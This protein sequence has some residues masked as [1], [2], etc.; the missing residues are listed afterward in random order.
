MVRTGRPP[1][2]AAVWRMKGHP[3][4]SCACHFRHAAGMGEQ[5][6]GSDEPSDRTFPEAHA[7]PE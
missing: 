3:E 1:Q 2:P 5:R 4:A 7:R 6:A